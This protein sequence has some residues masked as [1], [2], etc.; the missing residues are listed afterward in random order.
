MSLIPYLTRVHFAD[1]VLEDALAEETARLGLSRPMLLT[2]ACGAQADLTERVECALPL[3]CDPV[4]ADAALPLAALEGI[5]RGR[6]CDGVL[7][8]GG[9]QAQGRAMDLAAAARATGGRLAVVALP[10]TIAALGLPA[11]PTTAVSGSRAVCPPLPCVVLCDP[12]L[13]TWAGPRLTAAG[14]MDVL[15]HCVETYLSAT[16]NPPADGMALDG[17]RRVARWLDRAVACG[18]DRTARRELLAAA[19]NAA[20]AGQKGL[21]AGHALAT[22]LEGEAPD[23]PP[24]GAWH[25]AILPAV[26]RFNAPA[27]GDRF[28]ALAEAMRLP[29]GTDLPDAIRSFGLR[30]GLPASVPAGA[31]SGPARDRVAARAAEDPANRSNPRHATIRDFRALLDEVCS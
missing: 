31:L 21:G 29:A 1:R 5:L 13:T 25:A 23:P 7:A 4:R 24:H 20:L 26:L 16:W 9:A 3:G 22:A 28:E 11:V 8:L 15:L 14:G 17:L 19:L 12:T 18:T 30:L 2:D 10:T 27:A 6:G